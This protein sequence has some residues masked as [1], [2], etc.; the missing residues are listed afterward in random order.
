MA[1][2]EPRRSPVQPGS[3]RPPD[4]SRG[5][6]LIAAER[7]RQIMQEGWTPEHDDEHNTGELGY[8][9]AA[10]MDWADAQVKELLD[11]SDWREGV[12]DSDG[13]PFIW[14]WHSLWWKPS[15]DPIRNLV[16]AGALI[17]AEI[18]RLQRA[19]GPDV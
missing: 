11:V 12:L 13:I 2:Q 19:G 5:V 9:A 17:A 8:A 15:D 16:K 10:Y 18:D 4:A 6:R 3:I 14:P 7:Q 1:E